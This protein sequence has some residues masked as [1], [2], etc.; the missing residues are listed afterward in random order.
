ME[1]ISDVILFSFIT[2]ECS[3]MAAIPQG[4]FAAIQIRKNYELSHAA[5]F[6]EDKQDKKN[7]G[8]NAKVI[9]E[10]IYR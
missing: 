6:E 8:F 4:A 1:T 7:T 2:S 3:R 9:Q 5:K 10:G